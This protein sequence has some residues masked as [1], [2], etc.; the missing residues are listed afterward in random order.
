MMA[1]VAFLEIPDNRAAISAI[2]R[3]ALINIEHE[4]NPTVYLVLRVSTGR[5]LA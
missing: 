2:G 3:V 1:K 5:W 4:G